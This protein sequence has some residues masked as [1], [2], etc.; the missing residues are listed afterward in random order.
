MSAVKTILGIVVAIGFIAIAGGIA[1]SVYN[2]A[3][4]KKARPGIMLIIAGV[5][6]VLILGTLNAGLVLVQPNERG[7]VFRQTASGDDALLEPLNPGLSWVIPF[8]DQVIIYDIG[9]RSVTMSTQSAEQTGLGPVRAITSDGQVVNLDITVVYRLNPTAV[10]DVHRNWRSN[11]ESGFI[12][13]QARAEVRDEISLYGAEEIYA[14]GKAQLEAGIYDGMTSKLASEG[15]ELIDVLVRNIEFSE[16]FADAIELKQIA[17]QEAQRAAFRV[18]QAQQEAEQAR[19]EAQGRA[20]AVVIEAQG[21]AEAMIIQAEAEQQALQLINSILAQNP[22]LI[23]WQYINE[24]G[25]QI[26]MIIVPSDTPFLF[27][28]EQLMAQ[29]GTST[30]ITAPETTP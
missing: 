21:D 27:D 17:E 15:F 2:T 16:Q 19:V 6:I 4:N 24:L 3:R 18:Q 29:N 9:R 5:I 8:I 22:N 13:P 20:D 14:G 28:L 10:N 23:Q 25:D 26:Q 11:Y 30:P 7:V 1:L 12:L